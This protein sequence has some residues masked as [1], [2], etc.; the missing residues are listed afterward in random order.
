MTGMVFTPAIS[1]VMVSLLT[2]MWKLPLNARLAGA[3]A[4]PDRSRGLAGHLHGQVLQ[5]GLVRVD[6]QCGLRAPRVPA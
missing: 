6:A 4:L 3:R 1:G 5:D 2:M